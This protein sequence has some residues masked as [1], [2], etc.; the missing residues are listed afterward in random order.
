MVHSKGNFHIVAL[1]KPPINGIT[2]SVT[3]HLV[4][5]KAAKIML[6]SGILSFRSSRSRELMIKCLFPGVNTLYK[7]TNLIKSDHQAYD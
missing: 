4:K 7:Y 5:E 6:P 2:C 3:V 1:Q